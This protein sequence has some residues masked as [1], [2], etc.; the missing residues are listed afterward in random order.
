MD[1]KNISAKENISLDE[2]IRL[3]NPAMLKEPFPVTTN[4]EERMVKDWIRKDKEQRDL[5]PSINLVELQKK[6]ALELSENK[7]VID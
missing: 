5:D 3:N 2:W 4:A 6:F 1:N 7:S